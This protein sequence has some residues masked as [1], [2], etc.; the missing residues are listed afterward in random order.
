MCWCTGENAPLGVVAVMRRTGVGRG[1]WCLVAFGA[2]IST[3]LGKLLCLMLV[4][5][6]T[7]SLALMIQIGKEK[8]NRKIGKVEKSRRVGLSIALKNKGE[9]V[10]KT[11]HLLPGKRGYFL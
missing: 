5:K 3:D 1:R 7:W 9:R 6:K 2:P 11:K 4:V 10:G 8:S